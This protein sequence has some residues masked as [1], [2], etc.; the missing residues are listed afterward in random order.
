MTEL[1]KPLVTMLLHNVNMRPCDPAT[2]EQCDKDA[3]RPLQV[4]EDHLEEAQRQQDELAG[5]LSTNPAERPE[6]WQLRGEILAHVDR[7]RSELEPGHLP[8]PARARPLVPPLRAASLRALRER[9]RGE[10]QHGERHRG[11]RHRGEP[12]HGERHPSEW[13]ADPSAT[14]PRRRPNRAA[15]RV[16]ARRTASRVRA[17]RG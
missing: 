12:Q 3:K 16:R 10:P 6:G 1:E 2:Y 14:G 13:H 15:M 7:L 9:H 8:A 11:E 17:R 4:L 5:L